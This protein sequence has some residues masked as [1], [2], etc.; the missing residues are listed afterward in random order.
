MPR[1]PVI[2][3]GRTSLLVVRAALLLLPAAATAA[4]HP[5]FAFRGRPIAPQCVAPFSVSGAEAPP[6]MTVVD[7]DACAAM[8]AS[9][10]AFEADGEGRRWFLRGD[11]G[12]NEGSFGY[13][14]RGRTS[15]G[16]D[17]LEVWDNGG[18]SG[19][20]SAVFVVQ[21]ESGRLLLR[22]SIEGGDRCTA[23]I[24]DAAVEGSDVTVGFHL[25]AADLIGLAADGATAALA[26]AALDL[27]AGPPNDC[28]GAAR[29]RYSP[30]LSG[31]PALLGI[32]FRPTSR[33]L[34]DDSAESR[35]LRAAFG[36]APAFIELRALDR[37]VEAL[38]T[39]LD[40]Q[41]G[42]DRDAGTASD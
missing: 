36:V 31:S 2:R 41:R 9:P 28:E 5:E 3:R 14:H 17:V 23:G 6:S 4:V 37:A 32:D 7:L 11:D 42:A 22:R 16:L 8:K 1:D 40:A 19:T 26:S 38:R 10:P 27:G 33:L 34:A 21:I 15:D 18:G 35:C 30:G 12:R 24:S 13:R 25:G 39:C 29:Y 20:Y